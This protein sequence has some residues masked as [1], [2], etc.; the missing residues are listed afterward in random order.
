MSKIPEKIPAKIRNWLVP[1]GTETVIPA[2]VVT[3]SIHKKYRKFQVRYCFNFGK[4]II[5]F[6]PCDLPGKFPTYGLY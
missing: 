2:P 1:A 3:G 6:L 5:N 4:G